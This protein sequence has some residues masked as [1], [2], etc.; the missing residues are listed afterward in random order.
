MTTGQIVFWSGIAS[1]V[2]TILL[3]IFFAVKKPQYQPDGGVDTQW[4]TGNTRRLRN[5][6]PTD[7]VPVPAQA[8]DE[9]ETM[10]VSGGDETALLS[11]QTLLLTC[12]DERNAP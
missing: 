11:G 4:D 2:F 12:E 5:G 7:S 9:T 6:Y 8:E 1:L 10:P 3:V